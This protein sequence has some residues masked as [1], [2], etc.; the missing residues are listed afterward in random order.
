MHTSKTGKNK[1]RGSD[2][3]GGQNDKKYSSLKFKI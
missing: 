2:I 1:A 3:V